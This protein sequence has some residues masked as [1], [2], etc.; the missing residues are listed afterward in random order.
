MRR[1]QPHI[2]D[3]RRPGGPATTVVGAPHLIGVGVN[4]AS[5]GRDAVVL[6]SMFARARQAE[7]MLI[8]VYEEPLLEGVVPAE[9]GW[10]SVETASRAMLARTRESLAPQA[11]IAVESNPLAW[12]G[13]LQVA[14]REHRDL[15]V[16]GSTRRAVCG[17]AALGDT[18]A[19]L[20]SRAPCPVA[21]APRGMEDDA[22]A[23]L[24]RVGVASDASPESEAA[25]ALAR[26]LARGAG[27][28]LRV[29]H[30][31]HATPGAAAEA[32]GDLGAQVDL[33][34]LGAVSS[35]APRSAPLARA[36]QKLLSDA[37]AP[38]LVVP[39]RV[40]AAAI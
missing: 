11:R 26:S 32:L 33:L 7:V 4:G 18:T 21:V 28:D 19:E 16:M 31:D 13:L 15:L 8:A 24:E 1:H 14:L 23:R 3:R 22:G 40:H 6:A 25:V 35:P 37:P 34:V 38:M 36:T 30:L 2:V 39:R 12:R 10:T 17:H 27:A 5:G 9:L 20:L 29:R